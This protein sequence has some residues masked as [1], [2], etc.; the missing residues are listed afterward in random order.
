MELMGSYPDHEKKVCLAKLDSTS[1]A[2]LESKIT[3]IPSALPKE[4]NI[5]YLDNCSD[6]RENYIYVNFGSY[7]QSFSYTQSTECRRAEI[8]SW[9]AD[10]NHEVNLHRKKIEG[11]KNGQEKS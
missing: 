4:T 2:K 11:C 7:V 5:K 9:L 3:A 8:P 1:L 10:L 6:E